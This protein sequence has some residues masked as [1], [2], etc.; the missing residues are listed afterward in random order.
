MD[1]DPYDSRKNFPALEVAHVT[2]TGKKKK[3]MLLE[4][5]TWVQG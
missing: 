5:V 1:S 3:S 4:T 2:Q